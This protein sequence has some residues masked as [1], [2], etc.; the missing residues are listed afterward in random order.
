MTIKELSQL[1]YL[2][3]EIEHDR[4]R[5]GRLRLQM[6]AVSSP[7][8]GAG[9]LGEKTSRTERIVTEIIDLEKSIE[10]KSNYCIMKRA[11]W[12]GI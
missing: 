7:L 3:R 5:L 1:Y 12:K 8:C 2:K 6:G 10:K 4:E 11:N 9:S